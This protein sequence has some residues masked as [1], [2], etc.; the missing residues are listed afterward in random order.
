ML[1]FTVLFSILGMALHAQAL[2]NFHVE[3]T[4]SAWRTHVTGQL[5][6]GIIPIDLRS[7]LNLEDTYNFQGRLVFKPGKRHRI[8]VDGGPYESSGTNQLSRT[9][10]YNG[11]TYS[12][13]DVIHS[14]ASLTSIFGGYQFDVICRDQGHFGLLIGGVYLNAEGTIRSTST[15]LSATRSYD[16]GLPLAGTEFRVFLIPGTHLLNVN[17]EVRG[18]EFGG[19]GHYVRAMPAVG[20]SFGRVTLQAG[21]VFLDADIHENRPAANRTGIA[22]Q[23]SGPIFG[24]QF[25][26]R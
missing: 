3:V 21:Y 2:E 13:R 15:G 24:I 9:I 14:N 23:M 6:S 26:D 25:R 4:A 8:I 18:M 17:G 16:L 22:P 5:Q 10:V 20:L 1:R 19:Y 7:D 11:S 12:V